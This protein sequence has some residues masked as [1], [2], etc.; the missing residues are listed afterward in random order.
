KTLPNLSDI[1][2]GRTPIS[3]VRSLALEDLM[4]RRPV[5]LD[6]DRVHRLVRGR[7]VLVTG[8]GGSI[9][10]ELSRQVARFNPQSLVLL[11]HYENT[12]FELGQELR[13][14]GLAHQLAVADICD[15]R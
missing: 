10:S 12:L 3:E 5:D 2:S 13:D 9:G 11:D 15:A 7:R 4:S 8:A 14:R 1:L 6:V